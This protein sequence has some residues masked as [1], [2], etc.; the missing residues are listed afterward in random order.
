L[1]S[2]LLLLPLIVL[3]CGQS[4]G[5]SQGNATA[6]P[7]PPSAPALAIPTATA[8]GS[9]FDLEYSREGS[10]AAGGV[11]IQWGPDTALIPL[12]LQDG[13]YTGSYAGEFH[14][15]ASGMCSGTYNYPV[16]V[17]VLAAEDGS[18][19]LDFSVT[20]TMSMYGTLSCATGP[21]G[22][23]PVT[24]TRA[25]TLPAEDGASHVESV[26]MQSFG[27]LT[28]TYTLMLR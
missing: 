24:F 27:E 18:G 4:P 22:N 11:S 16:S 19:G 1:A 15:V 28:D 6:T 8:T 20:A 2:L 13:A 26:P 12:E 23:A 10:L 7:S 14:A 17:D 21:M 9:Q 25:F 3:A 5:L